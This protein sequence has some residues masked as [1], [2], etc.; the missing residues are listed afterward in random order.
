MSNTIKR[1]LVGLVGIPLVLITI[2][3]GGIYFFILCI[4]I[5]TLCLW[6]FLKIFENKNIFALKIVTVIISIFIF[7]LFSQKYYYSI[8]L[9]IIP[10]FI[11]VFREKKR[12]PLNS[13]LSV[14]G[15]IYITIPFIL[16]NELGENTLTIFYLFILIWACD[17]FAYFGG[18]FIGKHK[19]TSISPKKTIEGAVIGLLFTL[20]SSI[21]FHYLKSDFLNLTDSIILGMLIGIVSQVGDNFESL[22]KRYTDVK[23]S[24]GIIPGHGGLLDRFDSLIFVTPLI[25][26]YFYYIK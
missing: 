2:Y 7:I 25:Y 24:S 1:I 8:G 3:L 10:I 22:L 21:I 15:V 17:T 14:F 4:I 19:L 16:L 26:F 9:L 23:D 6:E 13:I 12:N 5:Q 18:K 20:I 11:E